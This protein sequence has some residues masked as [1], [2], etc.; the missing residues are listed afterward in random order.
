MEQI[1]HHIS[2]QYKEIDPVEG[3]FYTFKSLEDNYEMDYVLGNDFFLDLKEKSYRIKVKIKKD[4]VKKY[5]DFGTNEE[6]IKPSCALQIQFYE[7]VQCQ[8]KGLNRVL[9][10]ES[11]IL[12]ILH[13]LQKGAQLESPCLSCQ[14]KNNESLCMKV[15]MAQEYI[16]SHLS[17]NLTIPSIAM[18]V[19]TNQNYLKKQF[20][21]ILGCTI[22]EFIRENRMTKAK[23]LLINT[24]KQIEEIALESGY[25]SISSFSQAFKSF[26]GFS[27]SSLTKEKITF[28]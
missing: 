13:L 11:S 28:S 26:Y 27:P 21:E 24:T 16:L 18:K 7:I 25:S 1:N 22:F 20:K 6:P 8:L 9:F 14:T 5:G 3:S 2:I 12:F 15:K 10:M 23:F 19:G 4:Y 17:E